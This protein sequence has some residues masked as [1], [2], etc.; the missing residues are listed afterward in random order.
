MK[1]ISMQRVATFTH[2]LSGPLSLGGFG[3]WILSVMLTVLYN[4]SPAL[5]LILALCG[6]LLLVASAQLHEYGH[7]VAARL[8]GL[9]PAHH[10]LFVPASPTTIAWP[11]PAPRHELLI[12][13]AGPAA[14]LLAGG[15]FQWM[16]F[17]MARLSSVAGDGA[18]DPLHAVA[19]VMACVSGFNLLLGLVNLAPAFPLD[20]G[21]VLRGA[22]WALHGDVYA[23]TRTTAR[24]G[25]ILG[26]L[27]G[28]L[29]GAAILSGPQLGLGIDHVGGIWLIVIGWLLITSA[30][31]AAEQIS[32]ERTL[33]DVPVRH[34]ARELRPPI[35]TGSS[36]D[37]MVQE[38]LI[39]SS[40][41]VV[42]VMDRGVLLGIITV[43]DLR[44][45]V[46]MNWA[47]TPVQ[48]IMSPVSDAAATAPDES[49]VIALGKLNYA[50]ADRIPVLQDGQLVG[51]LHREDI[52]R[53]FVLHG[54][55]G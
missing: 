36:I 50:Q 23:A 46:G 8:C 6:G 29:G 53:W 52:A 35:A 5:S 7:L 25:G 15:A 55:N 49:A 32:F 3:T 44:R 48:T 21:R 22:A 43:E 1:R 20:G 27:C 28:V 37:D 42:P 33:Q 51:I 9:S 26:W 31:Q 24:I 10:A 39:L 14:S 38:K 30:G 34:L 19:S 12:A 54:A 2:A 11:R 13:G 45:A 17:T 18:S 4:M 40:R 41:S 47:V 16:S